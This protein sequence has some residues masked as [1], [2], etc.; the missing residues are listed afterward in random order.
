ME[1]VCEQ[2]SEPAWQIPV[3]PLNDN[4]QFSTVVLSNVSIFMVLSCVLENV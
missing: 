3:N 2:Y 4:V 1:V